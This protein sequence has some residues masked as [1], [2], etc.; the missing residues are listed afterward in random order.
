MSTPPPHTG[1]VTWRPVAMDDIPA[2]VRLV[3]AVHEVEHLEFVG[4]PG[5]WK[6]WLDQFDLDADTHLALDAAGEIVAVG[7][8]YG[9]DSER[10]ARAILW[11]DAHPDR[12]DLEKPILERAL[13]VAHRQMAASSHQEK[14]I[15]VSAEEHRT[16]RRELIAAAGFHAAR[17][18]VEMKRSLTENLPDRQPLPEGVTVVPW[19]AEMDE[20]AR[21]VSNAAFAD[22]WGS[23]PIDPDTWGSMVMDDETVRRDL[24]FIAMSGDEAVAICLIENDLEEDADSM[25]ISRVG[26]TPDWQRRGLASALLA[27]SIHSGAEAGLLRTA[28]DVDEESRFD[29]TAVYAALGY[30]VTS[31]SITYVWGPPA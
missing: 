3:A 20:A 21:V 30:A 29:A 25:W 14:V 1:D 19:T 5:F 2:I 13:A 17:S 18:F 23:L 31:R 7:G 28:L 15:R 10:G 6:W 11:F 9:T 8:S 16:R 27:T 26:T 4:G 12:L 24:S 22:H